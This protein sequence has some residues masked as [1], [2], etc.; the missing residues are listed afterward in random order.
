MA[1]SEYNGFVYDSHFEATKAAELDL[2]VRGGQIAH[3]VGQVPIPIYVDGHHVC[4]YVMD[5]LVWHNGT[6]HPEG[7]L[8][9][10]ETKGKAEAVW[11]LKWKLFAAQFRDQ[12]NVVLTVDFQKRWGKGQYVVSWPKKTK[13]QTVEE[14]LA[15]HNALRAPSK[16]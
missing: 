16:S 4:D 10:I 7:T 11:R 1:K 9:Y 5:F 3:W 8:E 6:I 13:I 15:A 14:I 12:P 2:M